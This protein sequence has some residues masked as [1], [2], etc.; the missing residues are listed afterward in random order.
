M[1]RLP[2][3]WTEEPR[4]FVDPASLFGRD[5]YARDLFKGLEQAR[6]PLPDPSAKGLPPVNVAETKEALEIS[7]ELPGVSENDVKV[8][9]DHQ[10][11]TIAGEKRNESESTEKNWHVVE[12]SYGAFQRSVALPFEPAADAIDA[13][14]DKG[15]L[16]VTIRKPSEVVQKSKD[17]PIKP[18]A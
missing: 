6:W 2:S 5:N 17:I 16:R 9:L 11:L 3:L 8:S 15:V 7:V 14:F 4:W 18:S 13:R 12:R 1:A 10:R